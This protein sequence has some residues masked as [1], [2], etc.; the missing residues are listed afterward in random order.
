MDQPGEF[1]IEGADARVI[2]YGFTLEAG[3]SQ[4]LIRARL[5][6]ECGIHKQSINCA[7]THLPQS[8]ANTEAI[9]DQLIEK[10]AAPGGTPTPPAT[11][12]LEQH[13]PHSP[14]TVW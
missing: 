13:P 8:G 4:G 7:F 11:H 6:A 12:A 1:A 10:S 3:E 5:A 9:G 14:F 2:G